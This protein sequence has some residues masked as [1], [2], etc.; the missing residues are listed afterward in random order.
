[1]NGLDLFSSLLLL[2]KDPKTKII[3]IMHSIDRFS[4]FHENYSSTIGY[5]SYRFV[6]DSSPPPAPIR[7]KEPDAEHLRL[8]RG[9]HRDAI[10]TRVETG[11]ETLKPLKLMSLSSLV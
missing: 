3:Q 11:V 5:V 8:P 9:W 2:I 7:V 4:T 10:S 6:L 1:M